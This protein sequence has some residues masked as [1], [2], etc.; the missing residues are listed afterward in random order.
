MELTVP[1]EHLSVYR[2]TDLTK[3][4]EPSKILPEI[5]DINNQIYQGLINEMGMSAAGSWVRPRWMREGLERT[6][7]GVS[8][9]RYAR[10]L[11]DNVIALVILPKRAR[12]DQ[13]SGSDTNRLDLAPTYEFDSWQIIQRDADSAASKTNVARNNLLPPIVQV[14]M[15]ALD[16]ASGDRAVSDPTDLPRWTDGLFQRVSLMEELQADIKSLEDRLRK[17]RARLNFR[18]FSADVV[19]RGSKWSIEKQETQN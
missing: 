11:A 18:I 7:S 3:K 5:L 2:R 16:E 12:Y 9:F 13:I 1:T 4:V 10:I 8:R 6:G 19:L 15:V 14:V 17:D